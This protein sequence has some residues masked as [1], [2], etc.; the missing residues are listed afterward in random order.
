ML[1]ALS[2]IRA[3]THFPFLGLPGEL[4]NQIYEY[5]LISTKENKVAAHPQILGVCK[6]TYEEGR[7]ILYGD[8]VVNIEYVH[9]TAMVEAAFPS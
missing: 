1:T 2:I 9:A 7:D 8:N 5:L 6:Q 4:R 3:K